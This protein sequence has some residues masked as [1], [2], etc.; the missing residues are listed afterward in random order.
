MT[1]LKFQGLRNH[2][3][4]TFQDC[5]GHS[6]EIFLANIAQNPTINDV[7][8]KVILPK[9]V[10]NSTLHFKLKLMVKYQPLYRFTQLPNPNY[11]GLIFSIYFHI[12]SDMFDI[13]LA[14]LH[15]C[16]SSK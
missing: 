9:K 7:K 8:E 10:K 1:L 13:Y 11:I 15:V 4:S 2:P 3:A 16:G 5:L 14:K 12:F 6:P